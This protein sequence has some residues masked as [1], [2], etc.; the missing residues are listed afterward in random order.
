MCNRA[1][2]VG[3]M[4]RRG[5]PYN[6]EYQRTRKGLLGRPCQMRLACDGHP[7]DSAD[8]DPPLALHAHVEGSGCCILRPG[9]SACQGKQARMVLRQ[10]YKG[11]KRPPTKPRVIVQ[12]DLRDALVKY[13][14]RKAD[15]RYR[16]IKL[17]VL[18]GEMA[19]SIAAR[20]LSTRASVQIQ[21]NSVLRELGE[22]GEPIENERVALRVKRLHRRDATPKNT[23]LDVDDVVPT[24]ATQRKAIE[25]RLS[26]MTWDRVAGELGLHDRSHAR[27]VALGHK[28]PRR[29]MPARRP[30]TRAVRMMKGD[31]PSSPPTRQ[32]E[33]GL[34][35]V[36]LRPR[37]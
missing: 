6:A 2:T 10:L 23:F 17:M 15:G 34:R 19:D 8:H 3:A 24:N 22:S 37:C 11:K 27:A 13:R 7:A 36:W 5:S 32:P 20:L 16:L 4:P 35:R 9:C 25:L 28:V 29:E 14:R 33:R 21:I 26:G 1:F 30:P 18:R 12:S 31:P